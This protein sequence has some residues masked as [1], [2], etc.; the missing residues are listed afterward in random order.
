MRGSGLRPRD[1]RACR[2]GRWGAVLRQ[3]GGISTRSRTEAR[4]EE[5]RRAGRRRE[6][7]AA[8]EGEVRAC[9]GRRAVGRDA[10]RPAC[11]AD[12]ARAQ[13][14]ASAGRSGVKLRR[15]RRGGGGGGVPSVA[16]ESSVYSYAG[17]LSAPRSKDAATCALSAR[18]RTLAWP[19]CGRRGAARPCAAPTRNWPSV[20]AAV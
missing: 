5:P 20:L 17:S 19:P 8:E 12:G 1:R 18:K 16:R 4:V 7:A 9:G 13:V 2:W 14:R 11:A 15:R 6:Q 3:G 10:G